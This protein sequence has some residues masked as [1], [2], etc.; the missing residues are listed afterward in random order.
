LT[1]SLSIDKNI[2][3]DKIAEEFEEAEYMPK[4]FSGA[5]INL[6]KGKATIFIFSSGKVLISGIE[7]EGDI[8]HAVSKINEIRY[9][10]LR[11]KIKNCSELNDVVTNLKSLMEPSESFEY[12]LRVGQKSVEKILEEMPSDYEEWNEKLIKEF[13]PKGREGRPSFLSMESHVVEE[14]EQE[15]DASFVESVKALGSSDKIIPILLALGVKWSKKRKGDPPFIAGL[16]LCVLAASKMGSEGK[17]STNYYYWLNKLLDRENPGSKRRPPGFDKIPYLWKILNL[18][19]EEDC[20]GKRGL[21]T[22]KQAGPPNRK[23]VSWPISQALF[24]PEAD[25]KELWELKNWIG[26]EDESPSKGEIARGLKY[27]L[28]EQS[29]STRFQNLL[30]KNIST[31]DLKFAAEQLTNLLPDIEKPSA[32]DRSYKTQKSFQSAH[33]TLYPGIDWTDVVVFASWNSNIEKGVYHVSLKPLEIDAEVN[34]RASGRSF[35]ELDLPKIR[36]QPLQIHFKDLDKEVRLNIDPNEPIIF[37]KGEGRNWKGFWIQYDQ[38]ASEEEKHCIICRSSSEEKTIRNLDMEKNADQIKN[39]NW[40]PDGFS[41]FPE[42]QIGSETKFDRIEH[43]VSWNLEGGIKIE[44]GVWLHGGMPEV[45]AAEEIEITLLD[46]NENIISKF[47][48]PLPLS[49]LDLSPGT[50]ILSPD[51]GHRKKITVRKPTWPTHPKTEFQDF[52]I[53]TSQNDEVVISG[54]CIKKGDKPSLPRFIKTNGYSEVYLIGKSPTDLKRFNNFSDKGEFFEAETGFEPQWVIYVENGK[55]KEVKGLQKVPEGPV[56]RELEK[57]DPEEKLN[58]S[59][60]VYEISEDKHLINKQSQIFEKYKE[61]AEKILANAWDIVDISYE[62]DIKEETRELRIEIEEIGYTSS[63]T[64]RIDPKN[65][66]FGPIYNEKIGYGKK[67]LQIEKKAE[68]IPGGEYLVKISSDDKEY[69]FTINLNEIP[70]KMYEV[71]KTDPKIKNNYYQMSLNWKERGNVIEKEVKIKKDSDVKKETVLPDKKTNFKLKIPLKQNSL[72][73]YKIDFLGKQSQNK[74][75]KHTEKV[76]F[77]F[78]IN[79]VDVRLTKSLELNVSWDESVDEIE[80]KIISL[81][82]AKPGKLIHRENIKGKKQT[83][84]TV[85]IPTSKVI[86][87]EKYIVEVSTPFLVPNQ[88]SRTFDGTEKNIDEFEI[89]EKNPIF[90][91]ECKSLITTKTKKAGKNMYIKECPSCGYQIPFGNKNV[92]SEKFALSEKAQS[93]KIEVIEDEKKETQPTI[94]KRCPECGNNKAYWKLE[95]TRAADEPETRLYTCTECGH[96]WRKY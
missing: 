47:K 42:I 36:L 7:N 6:T 89:K 88:K 25:K 43:Q 20:E 29:G 11:R 46:N 35:M 38:P 32:Q 9:W 81:W 33:L 96:T 87:S 64:V 39:L 27:W 23:Y 70:W 13:Y 45:R 95:Q 74:S 61:T 34:V 40:L 50:Y 83:S 54:P 56:T 19:L 41:F 53:P 71:E 21:P 78:P 86:P 24:R 48:T 66:D 17:W 2:N 80:E 18:W 82:K 62:D 58:W 26:I 44:R 92:S 75:R 93:K 14:L 68:N 31:E 4:R 49:N 51:K 15:I 79:N 84:A 76:E 16:A 30:G 91:P 3:L 67:L 8:S 12:E 57:I 37:V 65:K 59:K 85:K 5:K 60:K 90:C 94:K 73:V 72:G 10:D 22:A 52:S 28:K 63:K 77:S 69:E 1:V 55:G